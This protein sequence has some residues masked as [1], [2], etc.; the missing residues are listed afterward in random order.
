MFELVWL[1]DRYLLSSLAGGAKAALRL[2]EPVSSVSVPPKLHAIDLMSETD[3][4]EKLAELHPEYLAAKLPIV[5][6]LKVRLAPTFAQWRGANQVGAYLA[7]DGWLEQSEDSAK[8]AERFL[9][10]LLLLNSRIEVG[11]LAV[12]L[13]QIGRKPEITTLLDALLRR[14]S[15]NLGDPLHCCLKVQRQAQADGGDFSEILARLAEQALRE[16]TPMAT[17]E[18]VAM[19]LR[20]KDPSVTSD[21]NLLRSITQLRLQTLHAE[22]GLGQVW[23]GHDIGLERDVAVKLIKPEFEAMD[24]PR[25]RFE[26]EMRITSQLQHPT[27]IPLYNAGFPARSKVPFYSMLFVQGQTLREMISSDGS[28]VLGT[29]SATDLNQWLEVFLKISEGIEYAHSKGIIHRDLKP[30]NILVG[31][32]GGVY[33]LDWGLAKGLDSDDDASA[34]DITLAADDHQTHAGRILGSP[35]YMSSEQAMGRQDLFSVQ[36]DVY[37]LGAILFEMLTGLPP[38]QDLVVNKRALLYQRIA[39]RSAPSPRDI[40]PNVPRGLDA[41]CT[42]AMAR[43]QADRYASAAEMAADVRRWIAGETVEAYKAPTSQ[44]FASFIHRHLFVSTVVSALLLPVILSGIALL[45]VAYGGVRPSIGIEEMESKVLGSGFRRATNIFDN[46]VERELT[47]LV[48][49]PIV[50][51]L[52]HAVADDDKELIATKR[53]ALETYLDSFL[54]GRPVV[55]TVTFHRFTGDRFE[56]VASASEVGEHPLPISPDL[57][58]WMI[59]LFRQRKGPLEEFSGETAYRDLPAPGSPAGTMLLAVRPIVLME[60]VVGALSVQLNLVNFFDLMSDPASGL[61]NLTFANSEG[62]IVFPV[63]GQRHT[64]LS[65]DDRLRIAQFIANEEGPETMEINVVNQVVH[66]TRLKV[67]PNF[68][69]AAIS[70]WN[71]GDLLESLEIEAALLFAVVAVLVVLLALVGVFV[72]RALARQARA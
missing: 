7:D 2:I 61:L 14:G 12:S 44:R 45:V 68:V 59:D 60:K 19:Y 56:A 35:L 33:V 50:A 71:Y 52:F 36:T 11:D 54:R 31:G 32:Y 4:D 29:S 18:E 38:H 42:K 28:T 6:F 8:M 22:G 25:R 64:Q 46:R 57:Q 47:E 48:S 69:Y 26:R 27:I 21:Q 15:M 5:D 3:A 41:I 70:T 23:V 1:T 10:S 30:D 65:A 17:V 67:E 55:R 62:Q 37:G 72:F 24:E 43:E 13:S 53:A 58:Q 16:V 9:T 39:G 20:G 51:D 66:V 40:D 63:E 49:L 34:S